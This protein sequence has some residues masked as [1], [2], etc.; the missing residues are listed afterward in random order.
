MHRA[1]ETANRNKEVLFNT[2]QLL[3]GFVVYFSCGRES[4]LT[5]LTVVQS[6][7]TKAKPNACMVMNC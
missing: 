5:R 3:C 2:A 6:I 4:S 7:E 1:D